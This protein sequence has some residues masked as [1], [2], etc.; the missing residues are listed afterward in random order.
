MALDRQAQKTEHAGAKDLSYDRFAPRH[1]LK[2]AAQ[3]LR[4][5]DDAKLARDACAEP[6]DEDQR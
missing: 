5:V 4:R 3:N 1:E 6:R 2:G